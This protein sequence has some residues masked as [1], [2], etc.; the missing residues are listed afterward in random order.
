M[1]ICCQV[2]RVLR[3]VDQVRRAILFAVESPQLRVQGLF[4]LAS[5]ASFVRYCFHMLAVRRRT[6]LAAASCNGGRAAGR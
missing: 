3:L 5:L 4:E 2:N 1:Q 6:I